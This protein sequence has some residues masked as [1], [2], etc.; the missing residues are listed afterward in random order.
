MFKRIR[1]LL[2]RKK[3]PRN[4]AR[5]RCTYCESVN[6]SDTRTLDSQTEFPPPPYPTQQHAAFLATKPLDPEWV[7]ETIN[8]HRFCVGEYII[9]L[10]DAAP[11]RRRAALAGALAANIAAAEY[12]TADAIAQAAGLNYYTNYLYARANAAVATSYKVVADYKAF[13]GKA[14]SVRDLMERDGFSEQYD[15]AGRMQM[16]CCHA[17]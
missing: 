1:T 17:T 10:A 7:R 15:K 9:G 6:P 4:I 12:A 13:D 14:C 16:N 8:D 5:P 2:H 11:R 3:D